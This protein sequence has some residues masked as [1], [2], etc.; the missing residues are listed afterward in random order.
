MPKKLIKRYMPNHET[1]R[2]H[3]HLQFFGDHL[4]N[5]NLWHLNRYSV[6][7]AF[8]V[9]LFCAYIPVPFQ[10]VIAAALAILFCVNLTISVAL[11]WIT[12]PITM[13][14]LFYF[15]YLVGAWAMQL[16]DTVDHSEFSVDSVLEGLGEI[17]EPFLLGCF[18]SGT[19]LAII[20][21]VGI[22]L[23]WRIN[24]ASRWKKR[25]ESRSSS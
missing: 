2:D 22:R 1:I 11:V 6:S 16:P 9:G 23:L 10:M 24:I 15:A 25:K 5:P 4:H 20:G 14:A 8:A 21:Y 12:N 7:G 18:I 17:W 13:P 19:L 3:K